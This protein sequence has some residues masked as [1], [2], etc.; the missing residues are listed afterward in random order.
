MN[1]WSLLTFF[2]LGLGVAKATNLLPAECNN[3]G[4]IDNFETCMAR[5]RKK[6][7]F[8]SKFHYIIFIKIIIPFVDIIF[9]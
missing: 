8:H 2:F 6:K 1:Y 7:D 3:N 5:K 4:L 9:I